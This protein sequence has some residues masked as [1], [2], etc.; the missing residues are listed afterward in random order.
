MK[1]ILIAC[2]L[3]WSVL[4]LM[5]GYPSVILADGSLWMSGALGLAALIILPWGISL[6][7]T[8]RKPKNKG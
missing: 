4:A 8:S 3:I 2:C 5:I 1:W 7:L 6:Y